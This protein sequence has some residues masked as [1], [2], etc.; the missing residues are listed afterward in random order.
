MDRRD[1]EDRRKI[2]RFTAKPVNENFKTLLKISQFQQIFFIATA[3]Y[4]ML[5]LIVIGGQSML[6]L[7]VLGGGALVFAAFRLRDLNEKCLLYLENESVTNLDRTTQTIVLM[8][9]LYTFF[10]FSALGRLQ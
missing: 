4:L 7:S 8:F 10:L 6:A 9:L 2:P 5:M 1:V 3:I